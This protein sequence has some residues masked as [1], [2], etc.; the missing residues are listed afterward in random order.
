MTQDGELIPTEGAWRVE[1][2][3]VVFIAGSPNTASEISRHGDSMPIRSM[4]AGTLLILPVSEIDLQRSEEETA[5]RDGRGIADSHSRLDPIARKAYRSSAP[6]I[7]DMAPPG[8]FLEAREDWEESRFSPAPLELQVSV[9]GS[10]SDNYFRTPEDRPQAEVRAATTAARLTWKW[11]RDKPFKSYLL[12]GQTQ[13]EEFPSTTNYGAGFRYEGRRHSFDVSGRLMRNR[14]ALEIDDS[15][16]ASDILLSQAVYALRSKR[17][18]WRLIGQHLDQEFDET[19]RNDGQFYIGKTSLLY[20][21]FG[22]KFAPEIGVGLAQ[23]DAV[24]ESENYG[25][26]EVYLKLRFSPIRLLAFHA[27]VRDRYR[28]YDTADPA[29]RN[30]DREDTRRRW[31]LQ[32]RVLIT[33]KIAWHLTYARQEGDSTREGRAFTAN[34]FS[35]GLSLKMGSATGV[36]RSVPG[37]RS[38]KH[39]APSARRSD[40]SSNQKKSAESQSAT[41]SPLS[42]TDHMTLVPIT[43]SAAEQMGMGVAADPAPDASITASRTPVSSPSATSVLDVNYQNRGPDTVVRI[44]ADGR[45]RYSTFSIVEPARLIIDLKGAVTDSPVVVPIANGVVAGVRTEQIQTGSEP[46]V[47]VVFDLQRSVQREVRQSANSLTVRLRAADG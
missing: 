18:E 16:E 3:N 32:S 35:S 44:K 33:R 39:E 45:L 40:D 30:Y 26:Q 13:Y 21:G 37:G 41:S 31:M 4:S 14:R 47:R 38:A 29:A 34:D 24:T 43:S 25:E 46:T 20:R 23:R 8:E 15:F 5:R 36:P 9:S 42:L 2:R 10:S 17:W 12:V 22:R 28:S 1:G 6:T 27:S 19:S 7:R 11:N